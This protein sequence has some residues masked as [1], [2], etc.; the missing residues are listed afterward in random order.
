M[1]IGAVAACENGSGGSPTAPSAGAQP[2]GLA[3]T[4]GTESVSLATHAGNHGNGGGGGGGG[5]GSGEVDMFLVMG[6]HASGS[7]SLVGQFDHT[8][9]NGTY[10]EASGS[11]DDL[12]VTGLNPLGMRGNCYV[13]TAGTNA[14][15]I[16]ESFVNWPAPAGD[17]TVSAEY[18]D[19]SN[20]HCFLEFTTPSC[21][22]SLGLECSR[23]EITFRSLE[24]GNV[25]QA[26]VTTSE[27]VISCDVTNARMGVRIYLGGKGNNRKNLVE[28][29]CDQAVDITY[30]MTQP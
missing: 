23:T 25:S 28:A 24:P 26:H 11:Y 5:K 9:A 18:R 12:E 27:D 20:D 29:R 1:A 2:L 4:A 19:P 8:A 21:P 14:N 13:N 6:G 22:A 17:V 10:F 7:G 3:D 30:T 16:L 15:Q